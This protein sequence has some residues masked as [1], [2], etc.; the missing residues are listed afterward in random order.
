MR[1][2]SYRHQEAEGVGVMVDDQGF[3][4]LA[5]A[6]P[7]LPRSLKALL[8]LPDGLARAKKATS[9]KPADL[10][11]SDVEMLPV[12]PDPHAMWC[13]AL[14]YREHI[15]ETG[16]TTNP[17]FPHI[18]LRVPSSI[19]GHDRPLVKHTH[20]SAFDYEGELAVVI[21]KA[22]RHIAEKDAYDHIAG[23]A[24]YNEGSV[25]EYQRHNRNFGIGKNFEKSGSFGPWL[26]TRDEAGDPNKAR[27]ITRLNGDEK[28]NTV[29][30]EMMFSIANLVHYISTGHTLLPGDVIVCGTPG[31]I[32]GKKQHMNVG[33]VCEVEVTGIGVLR[34]TVIAEAPPAPA[35]A[36]EFEHAAE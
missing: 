1:L 4:A 23:Y 22:G 18:F 19:V 33:D 30:G 25:R 13:L 16:L 29:A 14:N 15:Q 2:I 28:Q 5:K 27:I 36:P 11:M 9:G 10:R 35:Y 26:I 34:N 21:G 24:A 7:D 31:A 20:T 8:A 3:V 17:D 32:P 6:A 12:I